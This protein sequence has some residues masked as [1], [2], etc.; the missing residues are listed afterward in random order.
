VF[1]KEIYNIDISL[2]FLSC[3]FAFYLLLLR[4]FNAAS[5]NQKSTFIILSFFY[6][7]FC[8]RGVLRMNYSSYLYLDI[9]KFSSFTMVL[10]PNAL[11]KYEN[12][13][14]NLLKS[15]KRYSFFVLLLAIISFLKQG[16]GP[17]QSLDTRFGEDESTS[18][19]A[20]VDI[21]YYS[22]FFLMFP[23][24]FQ[25]FKYKTVVVMS[26][27]LMWVYSVFTLSRGLFLGSSTAIFC[28][29]YDISMARKKPLR[30]LM[31]VTLIAIIIYS[32]FSVFLGSDTTNV[33][34]GLLKERF[35]NNED[36]SGGRNEEEL[37]LWM[38]F[39]SLEFFFGRGFGGANST[40]IWADL[41]N[42]INM[43]HKWYL[44][45]LLKGGLIFVFLFVGINLMVFFKIIMQKKYLL[46]P[47]FILFFMASYGHTQFYSF[48]TMS[49]YWFFAGLAL[50]NNRDVS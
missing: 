38:D 24:Y 6:L 8:I 32:F 41:P 17:A 26:V 37:L 42:G 22:I 10:L 23:R 13:I 46:L 47:F 44:H 39:S 31:I 18:L 12:Q 27:F 25:N 33:V 30:F 29:I 34:L 48:T 1:V 14:I 7:L 4:N 45:L 21:V 3:S 36:F 5:F 2:F 49:I 28:L 16:I 20:A 40:W 50:S 19:Y 35:F 15:F 11:G 9:I 43:A